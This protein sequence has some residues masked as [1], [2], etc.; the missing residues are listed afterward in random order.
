M[1]PVKVTVQNTNSLRSVVCFVPAM[2]R[3]VIAF[4]FA[5]SDDFPVKFS[6]IVSVIWALAGEICSIKFSSKRS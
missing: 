5:F 3:S 1:T 4:L 6:E 2:I